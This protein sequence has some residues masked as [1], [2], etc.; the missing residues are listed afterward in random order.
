M[1]SSVL[2][3]SSFSGRLPGRVIIA[4]DSG[5]AVDALG[6]A[7]GVRSKRWSGTTGESS[8]VDAA[9]NARLLGE[10]HGIADRSAR[11]VCAAA[12]SNGEMEFV[13]C[14]EVAGRIVEAARGTHG[15]GYD[16]HFFVTELGM[17]MAEATVEMKQ[18]VSHRGR[19]FARLLETLRGNG[20]LA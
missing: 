11:F 8:V 10:L 1:R 16:P 12:W 15:F 13:A 6:G 20:V 18:S 5:L 2:P 7:P 9:N 14:G 19:A 17:T 3:P 4:D